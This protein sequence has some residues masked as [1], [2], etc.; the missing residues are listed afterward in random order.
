M[1]TDRAGKWS[2]VAFGALGIGLLVLPWLQRTQ[3]NPLP[4]S[5]YVGTPHVDL[6]LTLLTRHDA[7]CRSGDAQ[8]LA[9]C[10]TAG[11]LQALVERA[12]QLGRAFEAA[13]LRDT[14][15]VDVG[16]AAR[17][18]QSFLAGQAFG[19]RALT[20]VRLHP[21]QLDADP[22]VQVLVFA[23]TGQQFLLDDILLD[24]KLT[25]DDEPHISA[26]MGRVLHGDEGPRQ[27]K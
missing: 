1:A 26:W 10:V 11:R 2:A 20:A 21:A 5:F 18:Q 7:A 4:G 23:W 13:S 14:M 9:E 17:V 6:L 19:A 25:P 22:G 15:A 3:P 12:A 16:L 24:P 27:A 8:A